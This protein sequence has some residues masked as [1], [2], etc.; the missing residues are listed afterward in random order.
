MKLA[1]PLFIA[2]LAMTPTA[3]GELMRGHRLPTGPER[4]VREREIDVRH[5]VGDLRL[6]LGKETV[7]GTV[8]VHFAPLRGGLG[9]L[10]LD[11]ADLDVKDVM[12]VGA[13]G[14]L[15]FVLRD[16][17]LKVT[18]PRPLAAGEVSELRIDYSCRPKS[19]LYFQPR[20]GKRGPQVWNYGEGGRHYGWLPLYNDTND[21]FSVE[22]RLTVARP[23][24]ALANGTLRE[25]R[26]NADGTRTFV[27][28]QDEPIPN[29]LLALDAGEFARVDLG[30]ARVGG[31]SVPLAAWASPGQ[32]PGAA[33]AFRNTA[34]MVEFF[35][36]RFGY[37]YPW[38]KYDQIALREF[39]VGAMETTGLVGFSESHLH[40]PGDPPDSGPDFE[41]AFPLWTYED[42]IAHELA[43]HWFGDLVTC[44]SLG[45][46]FLNESFASFAHTLWTEHAYGADDFAYQR[47]RYLDAYLG[48]VRR[49]G[50]VR[51]LQYFRYKSSGDMYQQDTTYIKGALVLQSLRHLMGDESFF[52]G[53]AAYLKKNEYSEVEAADLQSALERSSG[54]NL[55]AFFGDWIVSGGGHPALE[56]SHRYSPERKAVDLTVRQVQADLPFEN[57]FSLPVDVE[58]RTASGAKV[59][60]VELGGWTT[61]LSLPV[62]GEPLFVAFDKGGWLIADVAHEQPLPELLAQLAQG[63]VSEQL[64]AARQIAEDHPR[65]AETAAALVRVLADAKAHWGVRQEAARGLGVIGGESAGAALLG[66][67]RGPDARVRRAAALAL[68]EAGGRGSVEALRRAVETDKAEDVAA[69]AAH[70]LGRLD[71]PGAAEFLKRQ[72]LRESRWWSAL[73][74]GALLGLGELEEPGLLAVF[75]AHLDPEEVREVRLAALDGWAELA[76]NDP[77]LASRLRELAGDRNVAVRE[78][79]LTKLGEMHRADDLGFLRD[80][81]AREPDPDLAAEARS[82]VEEIEAFV[83]KERT[84]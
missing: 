39:S 52:R 19:G 60:A 77:A 59:H 68:G 21:R 42:T 67:L 75:R 14:P 10:S 40:L 69:V 49:T 53:I 54:R 20:S 17:A 80:F 28:S 79:A 4:A 45:S 12:L 22:M 63:G 16:R 66:A 57:A 18:L 29:Y 27:W 9:A 5:L 15:A 76:P 3:R 30:A 44:R 48:Y 58:V 2:L 38:P 7:E 31:R 25:T 55:S 74:L 8:T 41:H 62:D 72:L 70:S 51:P 71:A 23:Y 82:A 24:Q 83:K 13:S 35:S 6:D 47:W 64:R 46:I 34:R 61:Q 26:E 33:H 81:A 1:V 65:Q 37:P 78:A 84:E 56:V 32:E 73:R 36:E 11:A 50:E 43:H